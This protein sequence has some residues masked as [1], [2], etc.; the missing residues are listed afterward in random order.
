MSV[1]LALKYAGQRSQPAALYAPQ[2][3]SDARSMERRL[4]LW[5]PPTKLADLREE[6]EG[7]G[8][9]LRQ[10]GVLSGA[11][12]GRHSTAAGWCACS[13]EASPACREELC[14]KYG[15]FW[16]VRASAAPCAPSWL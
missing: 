5:L 9:M 4:R 11:M 2:L 15:T 12:L 16:G 14:S 10:G 13:F 6:R 7:V 1:G 8:E 3:L